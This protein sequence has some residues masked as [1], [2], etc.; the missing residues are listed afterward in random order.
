[1][2]FVFLRCYV[3]GSAH[4]HIVLLLWSALWTHTCLLNLLMWI[5]A[6][7]SN[8][9]SIKASLFLEFLVEP[10]YLSHIQWDDGFYPFTLILPYNYV[11]NPF[12][13]DLDL[14]VYFPCRQRLCHHHQV[15]STEERA[16]D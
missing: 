10:L 7:S 6:L 1:M 14:D 12:L 3:P 4:G 5:I 16:K 2:I 11:L 9:S 8:V 15:K 13:K